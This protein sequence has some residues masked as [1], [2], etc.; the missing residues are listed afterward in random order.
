V[1]AYTRLFYDKKLKAIVGGE[2]IKHI[3][4]NPDLARKRGEALRFRNT[5]IKEL[6]SAETDEVKEV[7]ENRREEGYF[8]EAEDVEPDD[9][10]AVEGAERRR[11]TKAYGYHRKVFYILRGVILD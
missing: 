8:S 9:G 7:V 10:D 4:R 3:G 11:R 6:Y 1:Q 2:W 5:V